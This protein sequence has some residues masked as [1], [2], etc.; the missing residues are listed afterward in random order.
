[1]LSVCLEHLRPSLSRLSEE[2]SFRPGLSVQELRLLA[3]RAL[4]L[5]LRRV[6]SSEHSFQTSAAIEM[7]TYSE[8]SAQTIVARPLC[9]PSA[10]AID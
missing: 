1:M 5:E 6:P 3:T 7:V 10:A 4:G 2:P 8:G 9:P